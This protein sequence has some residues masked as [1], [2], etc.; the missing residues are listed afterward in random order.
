MD[1]NTV[2]SSGWDHLLKIWDCE[3]S[4]IKQDI[5]G[6][7][8][9][10]LIWKWLD[11]LF[12]ALWCFVVCELV[13]LWLYLFLIPYGLH[14][15]PVL[16]QSLPMNPLWSLTLLLFF[17]SHYIVLLCRTIMS[18]IMYSLPRISQ[19]KIL[20]ETQSEPDITILDA[21]STSELK[22]CDSLTWEWGQVNAIEVMII[23]LK[24]TNLNSLRTCWSRFVIAIR[25]TDLEIED[26]I[27]FINKGYEDIRNRF[28]SSERDQK[29]IRER[30]RN[31]L[32]AGSRLLFWRLRLT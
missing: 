7:S 23:I 24:L 13:N 4:G 17:W 9:S 3:L 20:Q 28:E 5:A 8:V 27:A 15:A 2:L 25:N 10:L 1:F 19:N 14:V 18:R 16:K 12:V 29:D 31:I 30:L 22:A 11:M 26:S 6:K 21:V 32:N